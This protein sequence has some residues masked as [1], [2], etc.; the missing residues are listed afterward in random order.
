MKQVKIRIKSYEE[1]LQYLES[2]GFNEC[3]NG[4]WRKDGFPTFYSWMFDYQNETHEAES[5]T[6]DDQTRYRVKSEVFH[7]DWVELV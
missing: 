7:A 4:N 1:I 5:F 3:S 6:K 2:N